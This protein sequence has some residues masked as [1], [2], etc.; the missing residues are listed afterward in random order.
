MFPLAKVLHKGTEYSF[1]PSMEKKKNTGLL[2]LSSA[3]SP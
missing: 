3:Y 1:L 2:F